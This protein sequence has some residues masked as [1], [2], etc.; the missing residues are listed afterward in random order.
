MSPTLRNACLR[1]DIKSQWKEN[2][3]SAQVVNFSLGDDPTIQQPGFNLPRQQ[4]PLLNCFWTAQGHFGACKKWNQATTDPCPCSEIQT[5][6]HIVNSCLLMKLNGSLSQLHSADDEAVVWLTSYGSW[7]TRKKKMLQMTCHKA[8][9]DTKD[10]QP[11]GS[12]ISVVA[13]IWVIYA[14]LHKI[15]H[16]MC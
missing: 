1:V 3:K 10:K 6:S 12:F 4:C 15:L 8:C 9:N 7:C 16:L 2:W 14:K 13:L 11:A 5:M